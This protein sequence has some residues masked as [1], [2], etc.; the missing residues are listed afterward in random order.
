MRRTVEIDLNGKKTIKLLVRQNVP[1]PA[2]TG[3]ALHLHAGEYLQL[4]DPNGKQPADFWAFSTENLDEC[5]SAEHTRVW[6]NRL[7]PRP[8]ESFHTCHRRPILQ[9]VADSCGVHDMLTAACD[10]HRYRLYGVQSEH[11]SC[12]DNLVKAMAALGHRIVHVP[13]PVNFFTRVVVH[14]NGQVE[15]REPPSN[16]RDHIVLKAWIDCYVAVSACPQEFNPVAGWFP[17]EL[18]AAVLR[19]STVGESPNSARASP[20]ARNR[21]RGGHGHR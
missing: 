19:A 21:R 3:V 5:L 9:L 1:I 18:M 16:P 12:A 17:T 14:P 7:F 15:T 13:S 20:K 10:A 11:A 6:V 2:R 4:T 8:G